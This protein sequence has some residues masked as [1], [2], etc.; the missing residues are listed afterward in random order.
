MVIDP[1]KVLYQLH[2]EAI[3]LST[4]AKLNGNTEQRVKA[5]QLVDLI[6]EV[7]PLFHDLPAWRTK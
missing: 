5:S 2:R 1:G 3:K 4:A 7:R 6:S